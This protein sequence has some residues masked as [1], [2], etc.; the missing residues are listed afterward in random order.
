VFA[1]EMLPA[2]DGDC[3]WVEWG[4][5]AERPH[6]MLIDAGRAANRR[7]PPSLRKRIAAL[8]PDGRT[9]ELVVATHMDV[10]HVQGLVP[11]FE[12][13][14]EGFTA[15]EVWFNGLR[16]LPRDI[17]GYRDADLLADALDR[18][19][20][21]AWNTSWN[22]SPN[23]AVVVPDAGALPV[24]SLEGLEI[25]LLSPDLGTLAALVDEWPEAVREAGLERKAPE[26]PL[27]D[28]LGRGPRD[29]GTRLRDLA[30]LDD[31]EWDASVRNRSSI[32]FLARYDDRTVLFGADAHADVLGS[33][34]LRV[35][36]GKV[37]PVDVCKVPHHGS[38]QNVK[39]EFLSRIRCGCWMISSSG[40]WHQHPDRRAMARI[41][42]GE[43]GQNLV[44]N[45]RSQYNAEYGKFTTTSEFDNKAYYP[46][47]NSAGVRVQIAPQ[48]VVS[49]LIDQ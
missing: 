33:A 34:L 12:D 32:A 5:D 2:R 44:F 41:L 9:F 14:P 43:P 37:V 4:E 7:L 13:P 39:R 28:R 40:D 38:R 30:H 23:G 27:D 42:A 24:R 46:G 48:I 17:L 19:L 36:A 29:P 16:N 26:L 11:L 15:R 47:A 8:P 3:L 18:N 22:D 20:P 1:V 31:D 25:T 35:E 49:D 10:D 6:R 21:W 45:Y